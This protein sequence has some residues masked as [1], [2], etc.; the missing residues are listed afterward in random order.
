MGWN[1]QLVLVHLDIFRNLQS[2]GLGLVLLFVSGWVFFAQS[3]HRKGSSRDTGWTHNDS[4]LQPGKLPGVYTRQLKKGNPSRKKNRQS[5]CI[6]LALITKKQHVR[7]VVIMQYQLFERTFNEFFKKKKKKKKRGGRR[8]RRRRGGRRRRKTRKNKNNKKNKKN[9]KQQIKVWPCHTTWVG[10][11][12]RNPRKLNSRD[13][14]PGFDNSTS[15]CSFFVQGGT[16][17][18]AW[19]DEMIY[20]LL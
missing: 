4:C 12:L 7:F 14:E 3:L 18:W 19:D 20:I 1:H 9:N 2:F 5:P 13:Y 15:S 6:V 16:L 10:E 8:R 11:W 17:D